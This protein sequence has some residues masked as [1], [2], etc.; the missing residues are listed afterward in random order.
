MISDIHILTTKDMETI[1]HIGVKHNLKLILLHGS[2]ADGTAK[3]DSDFDIAILGRRQI[4]P[5]EF[6]GIH[7]DFSEAFCREHN[8]E[9]DIKTLHR[10]DPLF[11]Y[12]VA[13]NCCLLFGTRSDFN[14]FL[15]YAF[16]FYFDSR[17]LFRLEKYL[18]HKFQKYLNE[19]YASEKSFEGNHANRF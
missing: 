12:Q 1:T 8:L 16:K 2:Y 3:A 10:A 4:T 19:K 18:V 17:D 13:K 9:L 11:C 6:V 15:S 14:A 5:E 7:H